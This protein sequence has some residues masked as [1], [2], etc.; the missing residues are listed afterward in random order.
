MANRNGWQ[1][2]M[3]KVRPYLEKT[4]TVLQ[5]IGHILKEIWEW[6]YR[7][8]SLLMTVPVILAALFLAVRNQTSLPD[9]VGINLLAN[10]EYSQMITR[11]TA[12]VVPVVLTGVCL[13]CM[14]VSKRVLYPWLISIFSLVLPIMIYITNVF[15]A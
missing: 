8:R 15:M 9:M 14:L 5:K 1:S 7:L 11:E 13:A 6:I 12:V 2:F 3:A 10:G 4:K